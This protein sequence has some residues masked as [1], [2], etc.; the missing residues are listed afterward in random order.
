MRNEPKGKYNRQ[1]ELLILGSGGKVLRDVGSLAND[2][3]F[4]PHW[5]IDGDHIAYVARQTLRKKQTLPY[6]TVYGVGIK[7]KPRTLWTYRTLGLGCGG[8]TAD[9]AQYT[10]W[11]ETGFGDTT[12]TVQWSM[13]RH[14]AIYTAG[15]GGGMELTNTHTRVTRLL[16]STSHPWNEGALTVGGRLAATIRSCTPSSCS[17]RVVVAGLSSLDHP[18]IV[19]QG[20]LPAWSPDGK[21]LYFTRRVPTTTRLPMRDQSG[22]KV[23]LG[24]NVASLWRASADGTHPKRLISEHA[25]GFGPISVTP[26]G[27]SLIFSRVG[28][29][30][31]LWKHRLSGGLYTAATLARFGPKVTIQRLDLGHKPISIA[32]NAGRPSIQP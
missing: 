17:T 5:A 24:T 20:E 32:F 29:D 31:N 13:K 27:A 28:N 11:N 26:D 10:F 21:T 1:Q 7:D 4:Y 15:C 23:T 14:V 12:S 8:G 19:A 2:F 3:D 18:R 22:N 9:P 6:Y 30:W 25:Y 16:G